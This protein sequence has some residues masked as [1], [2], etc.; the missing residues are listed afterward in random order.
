MDGQGRVQF[1]NKWKMRSVEAELVAV[2]VM[3]RLLKKDYLL[4]LP[5]DLFVVFSAKLRGGGFTDTLAQANRHEYAERILS[6]D[7]DS[8]GRFTIPPEFKD[9]TGLG[10]E[11]LLVGCVDRFEIW[12]PADYE[13]ARERE[14]LYM[15]G[16]AA[17]DRLDL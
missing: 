9:G 10:K 1:P 12:N 15:D 2:R 8:A 16:V 4:V 7:L 14:R 3:H 11:A 6:V 13:T 5:V 17:K